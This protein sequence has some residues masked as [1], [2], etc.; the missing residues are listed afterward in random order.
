[1]SDQAARNDDDPDTTAWRALLTGGD[2]GLQK[3][4]RFWK[5]V[6][7]P[8]RCKMCACPLG[9][10]GSLLSRLVM[11]GR[12]ISNP[13]ICTLC[14]GNLRSHPGGAEVDIS[15][16]FADVRGSTK[17]AERTGAAS[18]GKLLQR[19]YHIAS[20]AVDHHGGIVDKFLG[21]G[22]MALFVPVFSGDDHAAKAIA[23]GR[24]LLAGAHDDELVAGGVMF[25]AGVHS[26]TAFV[27]AVGTEERL[28]FTALGDTVNVAARLG[29]MAGG[30]E[31]LV[32]CAAWDKAGLAADGFERREAAISGREQPISTIRLRA[33]SPTP[34]PA[35]APQPELSTGGPAAA[36]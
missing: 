35:G 17:L 6:P 16:L 11:H 18:F 5:H 31:L 20:H 36:V 2:P 26:G 24:A 3:L 30:G 25:G 14:L 32:S 13:L 10:P 21:D 33:G 8:P 28:D 4:R 22:V 23:A 19:F 27:G 34:A 12:S 7:S 9:G 15:V 1:M 29:S